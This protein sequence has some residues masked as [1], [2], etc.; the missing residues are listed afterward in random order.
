MTDSAAGPAP[1][2]RRVLAQGRF[3][4]LA[5]L[6]NG[7]QLMLL[8]LFPL[9]ALFALASTAFLDSWVREF[10]STRIN[11]AMPG[12]L[13]LCAMSTALSGQ[14][15]ATGF[16]RRYGVLRFLSTTPLGRG[17]LVAGKALAVLAVVAVQYL[18]MGAVGLFL[19]WTPSLGEVLGTVPT[20]VLGSAAFACLG[21]LVA[22]TVRAEG[23][24][25][26]VNTLW[27]LLATVGGTLIP[28][29]HFPAVAEGFV[30][31]L[32]SGA[33]GE[34]MRGVMVQHQFLPEPHLVLL[35]WAVVVGLMARRWFKWS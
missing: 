31:L 30:R 4:T 29:R 15:I 18:I 16:D 24:L 27:V 23:T 3:E 12:V 34:A 32:P 25:A 20:L 26:V 11:L 1:W 17:G 13:T 21:Q 6:K 2:H 14:G 7:E 22:G 33:L 28:P 19:G 5:M 10:G 8:V 9:M 35:V